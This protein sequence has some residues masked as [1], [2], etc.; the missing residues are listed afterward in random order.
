[1]TVWVLDSVTDKPVAEF[2][3]YAAAR[4][5]CLAENPKHLGPQRYYIDRNY[6]EVIEDRHLVEIQEAVARGWCH[7]DTADKQM[8]DFLA[9]AIVEEV[10]PLV[11]QYRNRIKELEAGIEELYEEKRE[12]QAKLA[13]A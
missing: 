1:M 6:V 2:A 11:A 9:E 7:E 3:D 5:Y 8:D 13:L 12:L 10:F 4:D